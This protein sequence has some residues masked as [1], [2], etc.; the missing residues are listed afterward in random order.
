[1]L[2]HQRALLFL[3]VSLSL[4]TAVYSGAV[5]RYVEI[6]PRLFDIIVAV[7]LLFSGSPFIVM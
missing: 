4:W 3:F 1:M 7:R 2:K 5:G 6:D